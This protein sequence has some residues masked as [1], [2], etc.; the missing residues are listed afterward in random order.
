MNQFVVDHFFLPAT[1]DLTSMPHGAIWCSQKELQKKPLVHAREAEKGTPESQRAE[2]SCFLLLPLF[3]IIC[4]LA[5]NWA[6]GG[7]GFSGNGIPQKP[8]LWGTLGPKR[9]GYILR[10]ELIQYQPVL[11]GHWVV[12]M[13]NRSEQ[14]FKGFKVTLQPQ[15]T[16]SKLERVA[17]T[18]LIAC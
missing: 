17:W 7:S 6:Y 2:I 18:R 15:S 12:H 5:P 9:L 10:I 13:Q 3:P 4:V 8:K 14:H 1:P 16:E 11:T